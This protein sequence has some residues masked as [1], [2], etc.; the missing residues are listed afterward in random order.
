MTM[1]Q[2]PMVK[3]NADEKIHLFFC[4]FFYFLEK[5]M[6]S[7]YSLSAD[8]INHDIWSITND[9]AKVNV[10]LGCEREIMWKASC[11]S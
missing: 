6:R 7:F 5:D 8:M 9:V 10:S 3:N 1:H 11:V 2:R 4:P